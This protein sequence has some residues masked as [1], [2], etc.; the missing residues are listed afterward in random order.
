MENPA[1]RLLA[2]YTE[3]ASRYDGSKQDQTVRNLSHSDG[4]NRHLEVFGLLSSIQK[5]IEFYKT[6]HPE[7]FRVYENAF[8]I[9]VKMALNF[10]GNWLGGSDSNSVFDPTALAHLE[11]FATHLDFN[12]PSLPAESAGTLREAIA[13]AM[14]LL[15]EDES[16]TGNLRTYIYQLISEL[17]TALDDEAVAGD[18]DFATSAHRLWVALWAA[19]GQSKSR[20]Q[21]WTAAA[22]GMFR[23]AGAAALGSLPTAAITVAQIAAASPS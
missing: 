18:F 16:I 3:W 6:M 4:V 2:I 14:E 20:R 10:P 15:A 17:R 23:D 9:W 13:N 21:R 12:Q 11:T 8:D 19:A 7:G 5:S 22:K 1:R